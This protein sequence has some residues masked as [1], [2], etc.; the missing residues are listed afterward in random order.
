MSHEKGCRDISDRLDVTDNI[1]A[2]NRYSK[3]YL[4]EDHICRPPPFH[5]K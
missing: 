1:H 2:P 5:D 3:A 4:I